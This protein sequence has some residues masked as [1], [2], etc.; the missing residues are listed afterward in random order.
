MNNIK[1]L[2]NDKTAMI[3]YNELVE[4]MLNFNLVCMYFE[5]NG[6]IFEKVFFL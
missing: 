4:F 1:R 3:E 6:L 2:R 5:G